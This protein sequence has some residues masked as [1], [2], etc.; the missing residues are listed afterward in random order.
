MARK[1]K[2][3]A[4]TV[5]K[6][7]KLTADMPHDTPIIIL[8]DDRDGRQHSGPADGHVHL[9][10]E[11]LHIGGPTYSKWRDDFTRQ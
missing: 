1:K 5:G 2:F 8:L 4:L 9:H 11:H 3:V 6:F 7:R 10:G